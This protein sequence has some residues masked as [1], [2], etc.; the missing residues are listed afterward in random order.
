MELN[1]NLSEREQELITRNLQL[2]N[3]SSI[4]IVDNLGNFLLKTLSK[5]DDFDYKW[6]SLITSNPLLFEDIDYL[7]IKNFIDNEITEKELEAYKRGDL[8]E[9]YNTFESMLMC[10]LEYYDRIMCYCNIVFLHQVKLDDSIIINKHLEKLPIY[11][12]ATP[13]QIWC[14]AL[15]STQSTPWELQYA[16]G[17]LKF[18][19]FPDKSPIEWVYPQLLKNPLFCRFIEYRALICGS[20]GFRETLFQDKTSNKKLSRITTKFTKS[21]MALSSEQ[22]D[23]ISEYIKLIDNNQ[24]LLYISIYNAMLSMYHNNSDN[25]AIFIFPKE[26]YL[27]T[28]DFT[29]CIHK[30][31]TGKIS[32][33][34]IANTYQCFTA[35]SGLNSSVRSQIAWANFEL[36]IEFNFEQELLKTILLTMLNSNYHQVICIKRHGI[37]QN[38]KFSLSSKIYFTGIFA[39][40]YINEEFIVDNRIIKTTQKALSKENAAQYVVN[41]GYYLFGTKGDIDDLLIKSN[42]LEGKI[43]SEMIVEFYSQ[44]CIPIITHMKEIIDLYQKEKNSIIDIVINGLSNI[45]PEIISTDIKFTNIKSDKTKKITK[46]ILSDILAKQ[47]NSLSTR[48]KSYWRVI[49]S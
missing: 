22:L 12:E 33:D 5:I 15:S 35:E 11:L 3:K 10:N 1:S 16:W 7:K 31:D 39:N 9:L 17:F 19:N 20:S 13:T 41:R 28:T 36:P 25:F 40:V 21:S 27:N 24:S 8:R 30:S 2:Q 32:K 47:S 45:K 48:K 34:Y 43:T 18:P 42:A 29:M 6:S 44:Y 23:N 14:A 46:Q 37:I 4:N 49:E 38:G 26:V